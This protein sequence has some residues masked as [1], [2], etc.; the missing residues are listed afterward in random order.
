MTEKTELEPSSNYEFTDP[1]MKVVVDEYFSMLE[2]AVS[3]A[4]GVINPENIDRVVETAVGLGEELDTIQEEW[5]QKGSPREDEETC[6]KIFAVAEKTRSLAEPIPALALKGVGAV[7]S[8]INDEHSAKF[9]EKEESQD[10]KIVLKLDRDMSHHLKNGVSVC[11]ESRATYG[12][13][14]IA[15]QN[16]VDNDDRRVELLLAGARGILKGV[17]IRDYA[18][19]YVGLRNAKGIVDS[20]PDIINNGGKIE[21]E[22]YRGSSPFAAAVFGQEGIGILP[23]DILIQS[24]RNGNPVIQNEE[25]RKANEKFWGCSERELI[26]KQKESGLSP[27]EF[28]RDIIGRKATDAKQLQDDVERAIDKAVGLGLFHWIQLRT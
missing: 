14:Q 25:P 21:Y 18:R 6:Q 17:L 28:V 9:R 24:L 26:A 10:K 1:E 8:K 22:Y 2:S 4:E 15:K 11:L 13:R 27:E 7:V 12:C 5:Q 19:A 20:K 23:M 3:E 16:S